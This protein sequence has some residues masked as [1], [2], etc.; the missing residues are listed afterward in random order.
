MF[1]S[2]CAS[3]RTKTEKIVENGRNYLLLQYANGQD[4]RQLVLQ[5]GKQMERT[6]IEWADQI[7]EVL[8]FLHAQAPPVVHRDLTPDNLVLSPAGEIILIDFGAANEFIGNATGTLVG[9]QSFI[10]P[11]QFRGKACPQSDIYSFGGTMHFLLTG[12]EPVALSVS[13][14]RSVDQSISEE[15]DN[16][17]AE[18]TDLDVAKR[19]SSAAVL[20]Q[21][22]AAIAATRS[23][24][25]QLF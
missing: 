25:T 17:I 22:L 3:C 9:K 11:E 20:S 21:R 24:Q 15:M 18:M 13:H 16:L 19:I 8:Q 5:H 6:V 10:S 23:C 12:Q 14:P 2:I 1:K 4:L 7:T